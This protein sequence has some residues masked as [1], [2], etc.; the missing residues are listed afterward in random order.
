MTTLDEALREIA[1]LRARVEALEAGTGLFASDR[2][3]DGDRGDPE[4][5]FVPR[6]WRP[7]YKGRR[8]SQCDPE[9][10]DALAEQLARSADHPKPGKEKYAPYDKLDAARARSW[11]RR[12]RTGWKRRGAVMDA[13]FAEVGED[14]QA[15]SPGFDAPGFEAPAFEAP[16]FGDEGPL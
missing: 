14:E 1:A 5:K 13:E 10:L 3:L 2:D 6:G 15:P 9:F 7:L 12:L 4:V 16:P 11:A 8:Y